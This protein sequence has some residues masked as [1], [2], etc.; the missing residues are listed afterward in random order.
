M[1]TD[2][3]KWTRDTSPRGLGPQPGDLGGGRK[4]KEGF[5]VRSC[6]AGHRAGLESVH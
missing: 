4:S 3:Q 5:V 6:A 2:E 1:C